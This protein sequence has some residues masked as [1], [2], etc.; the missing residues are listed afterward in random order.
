MPFVR[1]A[2]VYPAKLKSTI[3]LKEMVERE[4]DRNIYEVDLMLHDNSNVDSAALAPFVAERAVVDINQLE[5]APN[6]IRLTVHQDKLDD[7][8]TPLDSANRIEE[9]RPKSI[10]NNL[11]CGI[12]QADVLFVSTG[13]QGAGVTGDNSS[14]K[15]QPAFEGRVK[16]LVALWN[17]GDSSDPV[18]HDTLV[19]E[20]E[21]GNT[22]M[23]TRFMAKVSA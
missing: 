8:A 9:M 5:V 4:D 2:N 6:T 10:Y 1:T 23:S 18:G 22:S 12:L 20:S 17:A 13:Y 14:V 16:N 19:Y 11:A 7:L 3:S 21:L 15:V